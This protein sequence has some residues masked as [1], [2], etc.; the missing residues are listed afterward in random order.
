[1]QRI[2]RLV[3]STKSTQNSKKSNENEATGESKHGDLI[4]HSFWA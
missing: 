2:T 1:L 3:P 4:L